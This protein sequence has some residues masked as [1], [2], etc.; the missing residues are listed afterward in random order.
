MGTGVCG[1]PGLRAQPHAKT[2]TPHE[3]VC[4]TILRHRRGAGG[5]RAAPGRHNRATT[6]SAPVSTNPHFKCSS[7]SLQVKCC[8]LWVVAGG[9]AAWSEW[10]RCSV[11]CGGGLISRQREC[12]SPVPQNGGKPCA[13]EAADYE[14]CNK[15]PC[16]V[17]KSNLL[18]YNHLH[19]KGNNL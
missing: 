4:A 9:W 5:A 1:P 19:F 6:Q 8:V 3:F 7:V 11:T 10:S 17:G 14:T 2:V 16:P 18:L 13:G 15:Q 12:S